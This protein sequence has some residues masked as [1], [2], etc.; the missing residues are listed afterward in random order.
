MEKRIFINLPD[1]AQIK[2]LLEISLKAKSLKHPIAFRSE[3][4]F[5]AY[6]WEC[7]VP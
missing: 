7:V 5:Y 1:E 6:R 2:K 3:F 4:C